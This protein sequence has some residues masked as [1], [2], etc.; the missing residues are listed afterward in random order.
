MGFGPQEPG[1]GC[2]GF[3]AAPA[4]GSA[5][6]CAALGGEPAGLP[7]AS[8]ADFLCTGLISQDGFAECDFFRLKV[9][10]RWFFCSGA[11]ALLV[12]MGPV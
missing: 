9:G 1:G 5:M 4:A 3:S 11:A 8:R 12:V 10:G 6:P 2:G 7:V